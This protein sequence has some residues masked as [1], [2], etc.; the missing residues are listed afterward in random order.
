MTAAFHPLTRLFEVWRGY[1]LVYLL[2]KRLLLIVEASDDAFAL[3][4]PVLALRLNPEFSK[5]AL[6]GHQEHN[7][8]KLWFSQGDIPR[9]M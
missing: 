2:S 3:F 5:S 1:D 8:Y 6:V 7:E 9:E 4:W